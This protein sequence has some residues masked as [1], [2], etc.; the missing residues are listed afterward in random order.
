MHK[1][2][3]IGLLALCMGSCVCSAKQY[4]LTFRGFQKLEKQQQLN[5]IN[6]L[7]AIAD[8]DNIRFSSQWPS[9]YFYNNGVY[10]FIYY[11]N[12]DVDSLDMIRFDI[13]TNSDECAL[14]D[15]TP[16]F[17]VPKINPVSVSYIYNERLI[18]DYTPDFIASP[19]EKAVFEVIVKDN[20]YYGN[21]LITN[22]L[23]T[24][25]KDVIHDCSLQAQGKAK[26]CKTSDK[27][28][29]ALLYTEHLLL[30]NP[31]GK[32]TP[33]NIVK[34]VKYD[35]QGNKTE[36]YVYSSGKHIFYNQKGEITQLCQIN[37]NKFRYFNKNLPDLYIDLDIV[38]DINDRVTE[39]IYKD[40]NQKVMR[41][42]VAEYE[43]GNIKNI[44]V[45]DMFKKMD[46]YVEP[47]DEQTVT[48]NELK[49]RY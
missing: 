48:D 23:N 11:I 46:W 2:L 19:N 8:Y 4:N 7:Q 12:N 44:H 47:T 29:N 26:I 40:R 9:E 10:S 22:T 34:Y 49:I 20:K 18:V 33:D 28:T 5:T 45:F 43:H 1:K 21:K 17:C 16:V 14:T 30:K 39:E 38:R 6:S 32:P 15:K 13:T 36:E 41:K 31:N 24:E 3:I 25:E 35:A 27:D 42:Y 37:A